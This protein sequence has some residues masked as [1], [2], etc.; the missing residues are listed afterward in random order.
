MHFFPAQHGRRRARLASGRGRYHPR[1]RQIPLFLR[2]VEQH[3]DAE[4]FRHVLEAVRHVRGAEQE[5]A[6]ADSVD[7]VPDA[8]AGGARRQRN[9]ARRADA[10]FAGRWSG[11]RR[12]SL[13]DRRRQIPRPTVPG[14]EAEQTPRRAAS[15][16]ACDP[17]RLPSVRAAGCRARGRTEPGRS[18]PA[19]ADEPRYAG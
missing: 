1:P 12:T 10:E 19:P 7:P 5:V 3:P 16:A 4:I 14:C 11:G 8:V 18:S 17:S 15:E 2:A 6:G 13:P 9:R